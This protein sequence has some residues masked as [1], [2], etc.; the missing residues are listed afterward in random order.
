MINHA[1]ADFSRDLLSRM[2]WTEFAGAISPRLALQD[3]KIHRP[4]LCKKQ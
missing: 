3:A 1:P 2:Y 4:K